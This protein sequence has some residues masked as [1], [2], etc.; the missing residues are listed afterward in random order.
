MPVSLIFD[1]FFFNF[2]KDYLLLYQALDYLSANQ[3][4]NVSVQSPVPTTTTVTISPLHPNGYTNGGL[5][6]QLNSV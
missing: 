3:G 4:T 5:G 6:A 2:Q 1:F